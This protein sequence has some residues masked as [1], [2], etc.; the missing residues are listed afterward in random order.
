MLRY[1]SYITPDTANYVLKFPNFRCH[2]NEGQGGCANG[3]II[4]R[5]PDVISFPKM[6]SFANLHKL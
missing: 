3:N 6:Y 5:T 2:G 4:F 1:I